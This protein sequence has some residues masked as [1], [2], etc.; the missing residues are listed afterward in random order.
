MRRY[1]ASLVVL[2]VLPALVG[3]PAQA[4][5]ASPPNDDFA[6]AQTIVGT[7]GSVDGNLVG[8]T[9]EAAEPESTT[10]S[11]S[12]WY[13]WTAPE[14]GL[15]RF[16]TST[17]VLEAD[18]WLYTGSSL[19][20]LAWAPKDWCPPTTAYDL[21]TQVL[22][23]TADVTYSFRL[24]GY[25]ASAEFGRTTLKWAPQTRPAND[26][27]AAAT[28]VAGFEPVLAGNNCAASAESGEPLDNY[29]S[30]RTVWF[31]WTPTVTVTES[32]PAVAQHLIVTVYTGSSVSTLTRVAR[33]ADVHGE[34]GASF[35]AKVGTTYRVQVDSQG[36]PDYGVVGPQPPFTVAL[37]KSVPCNDAFSCYDGLADGSPLPLTGS[38][39]TDSVYATAEAGEPAHA[40]SPASHS[41][42]WRIVPPVAATVTL[43]TVGSGIDTVLGVYTGTRVDALTLVA[44]DDDSAGAGASRVTFQAS[45]GTAYIVAVDGKAGAEGQVRLAWRL[46][47][48]PPR[49]DMFAGAVALTGGQGGSQSY[50]WSAS[51]EPGEPAHEGVAGGRSVWWRYTAPAAG[52]LHLVLQ[53]GYTVLSV[54]RG[55]SVSA[56]V[57]VAGARQMGIAPAVV[58]VDVSANVT[59]H[60]AV[61]VTDLVYGPGVVH[62][63]WSSFPPRPP[64]DD[65]AKA[66]LISG[67]SGAV[68]GHDVGAT[69]AEVDEPG[70]KSQPNSSVFYRWTAPSSGPY[71]FNT[72]TSDYDTDLWIYRGWGSSLARLPLVAHNDDAVQWRLDPDDYRDVIG[73]DHTSADGLNAIAGQVYTILVD[74]SALQ[75]GRFRLQW[76]PA[77]P[78]APPNDMFAAA[79]ALSGASG[80]VTAHLAESTWQPGEPEWVSELC[81]SVWYTWTA[82]ATGQVAFWT[83]NQGVS[84]VLSVYTGATLQTLTPVAENGVGI[85]TVGARVT[86]GA[87]AGTTYRIRLALHAGLGAYW[88]A[89]AQLRWGPPPPPPANDTFAAA[90]L[91]SGPGGSVDGTCQWA[92]REPGEPNPEYPRPVASVW[93][94][95]TAPTTGT[96]SF[97]IQG[98]G[99]SPEVAVYTGSRVDELTLLQGIG[100]PGEELLYSGVRIT[101]PTTAGVTYA[102]QVQGSD[103][104][105]GPFRMLWNTRPPPHDNLADALPLSG[106]R[107][108]SPGD[109]W[110]ATTIRATTE[111]GEPGYD[112]ARSRATVWFRWTA[113]ASGPVR[114]SVADASASNVLTAYSGTAYGALAQLARTDYGYWHEMRWDAVAGTSYLIAGDTGIESGQLRVQWS[115]YADQVKPSGTI[116]IDGGA[117]STTNRMVT[118]TLSATDNVG[119]TGVRIS[120]SPTLEEVGGDA[121]AQQRLMWG[122]DVD[123]DPG[124]V[125]WSL[126]D[127]FYGGNNAVGTKTVYVQ[128]RDAQ[129]NW[130]PVASDTIVANLT[131]IGDTLPPTGSVTVNAAAA[132]TSSPSV[133]LS[134]PASDLWSG[135]AMVRISNRPET[136]RGLLV[137]GLTRDWTTTPQPWSLADASYGGS[138]A[139]GTRTVY[140][141]FRDGAGNWSKVYTDTI[142]LD[143]VAPGAHAPAAVPAGGARVGASVPTAV[144]WSA[145]DA[146]SGV[147]AYQLEQ[148]VDGGAWARISLPAPLTTSTVRALTPGHTYRFRSRASDRAGLWSGWQH[149]PTLTP[150]L[151]QETSAALTWSGTWTRSAVAGASGGYVRSSTRAGARATFTADMRA[152]GWVA[153]RSPNRGKA[154][155]Y[156]DGVA[157]AT[158]DLYA[159]SVRPA[160]VVFVR[161]W[162]SPGTHAVAV[163]VAGTAGRPRVDVDAFVTLR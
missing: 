114:F 96:A 116:A 1:R 86:I 142:V 131:P 25:S 133:Q 26:N 102:I 92:T 132:Y 13:R 34:Y 11:S 111:P 21:T 72:L 145:T 110:T 18:L 61:D 105:G 146:T 149:G 112:P 107:G 80:S 44:A 59:Y 51:K 141:Q 63:E 67:A 122:A 73:A 76:A 82:P 55:S 41:L 98:R 83:S 90:P 12:I 124:T 162:T 64:N 121:G 118:L 101:F 123:G 151:R 160:R 140:V 130:S 85:A 57:R 42:W 46:D 5:V 84:P 139:N 136:S 17:G 147:A 91:L 159:T 71:V 126:T 43:S 36:N 89:T 77:P 78:W 97:W 60:I 8:A 106:A 49:N 52:R 93:Y 47:I 24:T 4:S 23:A 108:V 14:S 157:V 153:T 7:S 37:R 10:I 143:T 65:I 19:S 99:L 32:L 113:P 148:S 45:G 16:D 125:R 115:Q 119:V 75:Q 144:R 103:T 35:T 39:L 50:T 134:M 15:F 135:V 150:A 53:G 88:P 104:Q 68:D 79:Q 29:T 95:W 54:Y 30:R 9:V 128:W 94:R 62:L 127:L 74:G 137:Y 33:S 161:S 117:A 48:P 120:N 38:V 66:T 129:G 6:N 22:H 56:L 3:P 28:P 158:V 156:V 31:S 40:G 87:V 70:T 138:A 109:D 58:D 20:E 81:C 2:M 163:R 100:T 69:Q 152:V 155:I 27:F 154:T